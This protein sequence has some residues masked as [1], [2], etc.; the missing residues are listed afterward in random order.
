MDEVAIARKFKSLSAEDRRIVKEVEAAVAADPGGADW[1]DD[2]S[3]DAEIYLLMKI[4]GEP[5]G[6]AEFI[7][8]TEGDAIDLAIHK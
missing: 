8:E 7:V 6:I 2:L 3:R 5:E 1:P 4:S